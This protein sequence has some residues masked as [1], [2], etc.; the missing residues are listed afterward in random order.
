MSIT[1]NKIIDDRYWLNQAFFLQQNKVSLRQQNSLRGTN[2]NRAFHDTTLGG[3]SSINPKYQFTR[4]ADPKAP[5]L[6]ASSKG[7]GYYYNEAIDENAQRIWMQFGIMEFNSIGTFLRHSYDFEQAYLSNKGKATSV[8]FFLGQTLGFLSTL[9]L[10]VIFGLNSIYEKAKGFATDIPYSRFAYLK[11]TMSLYWSSATT[12]FN[13]ITAQMG[14]VPA[15]TA[16]DVTSLQR[17]PSEVPLNRNNKKVGNIDAIVASMPDTFKRT[18]D[19]L[20][21]DL[22]AVSSKGQRLAH[23][24]HKQLN[25]FK[26]NSSSS[27]DYATRVNDY[28]NSRFMLNK[29]TMPNQDAYLQ[30]YLASY[31]QA[32]DTDHKSKKDD[33]KINDTEE[34]E[35]LNEKITIGQKEPGFIDFFT[36]ELSDGSAFA[37]FVVENQGPITDTFSNTTKNPG[38]EEMVNGVSE[39]ARDMFVNFSGGNIGEG[40]I[41]D[42][43]ETTVGAVSSLI[44]GGLD[45]IGLGGLGALGGAGFTEFSEVY[46]N[47]DAQF[48]GGS[49]TIKLSTPYGGSKE[50]IMQDILAPLCMLLAGVLPK[51]TGKSSYTSPFCCRLYSPGRCDWRLAMIKNMTITRGTSNIAWS[52][53]G[54]FPTA[55]D[56]TFDVETLDNVVAMPITTNI[57]GDALSFSAFDEPTPIS[58]YL[59]SLS[60]LSLYDKY[61]MTGKIA[62]GWAETKVKFSQMAS[63]ATLAQYLAYTPGGEVLKLISPGNSLATA[64]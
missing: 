21:I 17:D 7:Q 33:I 1:S 22:M 27:L 31:G 2:V 15:A 30:A 50:A 54:S 64:Q 29:A 5:T 47:S 19:R 38:I 3:N 10:Q 9:P 4:T 43:V 24:Y 58:D 18:S 6:A 14:R 52:K 48:D 20:Y 55:I 44:A 60:G 61:Y 42:A 63:P 40:F 41:A 49:F 37:S 16:E 39:K 59:G 56:V 51:A 23:Q 46:D 53:I 12:L 57:V 28:I 13:K 35:T 25:D 36:S 45:S 26:E 32:K 34:N 8:M 62:L 11:P